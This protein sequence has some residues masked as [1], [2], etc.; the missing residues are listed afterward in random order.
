MI[1]Y[2]ELRKNDIRL[3]NIYIT[4]HVQHFFL[5][6]VQGQLTEAKEGLS[7][8]ARLGEQLDKKSETINS[9]KDQSK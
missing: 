9:L 5:F 6:C 1:K 7:A 3:G 2:C 8:A 4:I